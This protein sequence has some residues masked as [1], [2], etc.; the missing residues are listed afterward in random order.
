MLL[1]V[2]LWYWKPWGVLRVPMLW[3]LHLGYLWIAVALLLRATPLPPA[4]ALHALT[5]GALGS[6]AIGMMSRV[7]LGHSGRKIHADAWMITAFLFVAGVLLVAGRG[8][9]P[10]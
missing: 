3:I 4:I 9:A 2:R 10:A 8:P 7:A 1:L 6:L 5:M